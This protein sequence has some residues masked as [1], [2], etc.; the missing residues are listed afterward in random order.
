MIQ[1]VNDDNIEAKFEAYFKK[2]DFNQQY[3]V[4]RKLEKIREKT[5]WRKVKKP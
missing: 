3:A 5:I 4:L 1:E 2:L